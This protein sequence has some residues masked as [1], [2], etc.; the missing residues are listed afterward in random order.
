MQII[1]VPKKFR[2]VITQWS[3]KGM[4]QEACRY[5]KRYLGKMAPRCGCMPCLERY[6]ANRRTAGDHIF[7]LRKRA[8][9]RLLEGI[10]GMGA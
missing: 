5:Y 4:R 2:G 3:P 7:D 10:R 6:L 9:V 8:D 1:Q